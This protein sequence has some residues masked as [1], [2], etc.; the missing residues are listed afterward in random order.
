MTEIWKPVKNY[1]GLYEIS[2]Y[3]RIK[4]LAYTRK[5]QKQTMTFKDKILK[6][7]NHQNGYLVVSLSKKK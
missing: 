7:I 5:I 4:R 2:N 1:E 6:H 3:G